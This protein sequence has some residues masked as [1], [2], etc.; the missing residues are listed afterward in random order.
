MLTVQ[1]G[2]PPSPRSAWTFIR[3]TVLRPSSSQVADGRH[4][5]KL[6]DKCVSIRRMGYAAFQPCAFEMPKHGFDRYR[7]GHQAAGGRERIGNGG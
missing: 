5:D 2:L 1:S 4:G 7:I 6:A 3:L